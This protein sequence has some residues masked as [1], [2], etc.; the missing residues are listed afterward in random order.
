M[1]RPARMVVRLVIGII[2]GSAILAA[3]PAWGHTPTRFRACTSQ[4]DGCFTIGAAFVY[5]DTVVV[6][7][8]VEPD[9]AARL[10]KV[11]R[12]DPGSST[13]DVVDRVEISDAGTM[14]FRWETVRRDAHQTKPY[15]FRFKIVGHGRSNATE[16]FVLFGE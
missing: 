11:K 10:A 16:A 1:E 6:R 9:H 7:G 4:G 2:V 14:R 8:R 5:G 15:R 3:V 12:Q 13:W